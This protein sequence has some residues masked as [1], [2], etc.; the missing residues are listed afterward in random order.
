Q[1]LVRG[2]TGVS[3]QSTVDPDKAVALGAAIYAGI[4]EGEV[5]GQEVLTAWQ[6]SLYRMLAR[7]G[8]LGPM[9]P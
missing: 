4:L 8:K 1:R 9:P 3:P 2:V 6:A 7:T 5:E